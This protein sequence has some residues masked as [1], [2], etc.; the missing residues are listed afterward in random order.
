M[1]PGVASPSFTAAELSPLIN[2]E[3]YPAFSHFNAVMEANGSRL[4]AATRLPF[5][6]DTLRAAPE[7]FVPLDKW[8]QKHNLA[9]GL[10]P[11]VSFILL[12]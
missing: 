2:L 8:L 1:A 7:L 10:H 3:Y 6:S 9:I 4:L 11:I 5:I 12:R